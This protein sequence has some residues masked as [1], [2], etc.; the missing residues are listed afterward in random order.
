MSVDAG[1]FSWRFEENEDN[2]NEEEEEFDNYRSALPSRARSTRRKKSTLKVRES[3][4][5]VTSQLESKRKL[6]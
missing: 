6:F 4:E 2:V 1:D 3:Q 5:T